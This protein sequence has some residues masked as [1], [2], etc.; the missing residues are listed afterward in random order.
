MKKTNEEKLNESLGD[1][2]DK[3]ANKAE[4]SQAD[5]AEVKEDIKKEEPKELEAAPEVTVEA[6]VTEVA[7]QS[8]V[9]KEAVVETQAPTHWSGQ[10]KA[11]WG[12]LE[13]LARAEYLKQETVINKLR[14]QHAEER[15]RIDTIEAVLE[16]QRQLLR[17]N[18]GDE[19]TGLKNLFALSDFASKDPNGFVQWFAQQRGIDLRGL[20]QNAPVQ[21]A[22]DPTVNALKQQV[23][24]LNQQLSGFS[25]QQQQAVL[26]DVDRSFQEF[27][28]KPENK[29]LNEVREDMAFF[30]ENG[31]AN[32]WQTAY[33]MAIKINPVVSELIQSERLAQD[34]EKRRKVSEDAAN[35]ALKAKA[36]NF[37]TKGVAVSAS[38]KT[39]N[40]AD[41]VGEVGDRLFGA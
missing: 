24:Q 7:D 16:P 17:A 31:K 1:A 18:Y 13:P 3:A 4:V 35:K 22:I 30:I 29:Y 28:A 23:D 40:W 32:D 39:Q 26:S 11:L 33:N 21:Q 14:S 15:K 19:A 38:G 36:M 2:Y 6:P 12:K 37:N 20:V 9:E 27:S 25:K 10:A 34:E 8:V 5:E 41:T